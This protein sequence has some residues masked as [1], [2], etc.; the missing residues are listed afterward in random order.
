MY[1]DGVILFSLLMIALILVMMGYL[2]VYFYRHIRMDVKREE[3]HNKSEPTAED[4]SEGEA[5]KLVKQV[6]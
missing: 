2:G 6:I 5:A 4:V 1:I 3:Q